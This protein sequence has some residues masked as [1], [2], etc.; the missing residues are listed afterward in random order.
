MKINM[1][2]QIKKLNQ[3][4]KVQVTILV[5]TAFC[6]SLNSFSSDAVVPWNSQSF[7]ECGQYC[8]YNKANES[9]ALQSRYISNKIDY[10]EKNQSSI[11]ADL[12][13]FCNSGESD[14]SCF[15]RYKRIQVMNLS[16]I[17]K[18]Y[19]QNK[20]M[21]GALNT[22]DPKLK[23]YDFLYLPREDD[24]KKTHRPYVPTFKDLEE[25]YKKENKKLT[26]LGSVKYKEWIKNIPHKP[27]EDEFIKFKT[28]KLPSGKELS[29]PEKCGTKYCIDKTAYNK[30]SALYKTRR[31]VMVKDG[32]LDKL[33]KKGSD[34]IK[35]KSKLTDMVTKNDIKVFNESRMQLV[36]PANSKI[37]GINREKELKDLNEKLKSK[38]QQ[39][40]TASQSSAS[41]KSAK[42][43]DTE[44]QKIQSKINSMTITGKEKVIEN[45]SIDKELFLD[46]PLSVQANEINKFSNGIF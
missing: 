43:I 34:W 35:R 12:Q 45:K 39:R 14:S 15:K 13:G 2:K 46:Y 18:Q 6:F 27:S 23:K 38:I 36:S 4:K 44:I 19:I 30:A 8:L 5:L 29:I 20:E 7:K 42:V 32:D 9:L 22:Y 24:K 40:T 3:F 10:L 25:K 33:E 21:I 28:V 31:D 26:L 16:K 41:N 1:M 17:K 37:T 11:K